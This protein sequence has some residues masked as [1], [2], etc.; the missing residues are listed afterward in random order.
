LKQAESGL[1][2]RFLFRIAKQWIAGD[3]MEQALESAHLAKQKRH[4]CDN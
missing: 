3:T 2:E 4:G 1:M